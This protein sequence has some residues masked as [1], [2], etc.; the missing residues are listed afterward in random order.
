[1]YMEKNMICALMIGRAGS[2]GFPEKNITLWGKKYDR[3]DETRFRG[4]V[5]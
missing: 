1:M 5:D 4:S 2:R 3:I